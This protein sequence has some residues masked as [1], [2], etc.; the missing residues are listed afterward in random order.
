LD[1]SERMDVEDLSIQEI[2]NQQQAQKQEL[3]SDLIGIIETKIR[4]Q[5]EKVEDKVTDF[6]ETT[7]QMRR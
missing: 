3:F 1:K 4:K 5:N 2:K 6:N 7:D